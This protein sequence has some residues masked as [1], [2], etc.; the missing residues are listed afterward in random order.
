MR[1]VVF[2]AVLFI[3]LLSG[4]ARA[5]VAHL[6]EGREGW[7]AIDRAYVSAVQGAYECSSEQWQNGWFGNIRVNYFPGAVGLCYQW[8][9]LVFR[10]VAPETC[11]SL[12]VLRGIQVNR[13]NANEHH[14]VV[15]YGVELAPRTVSDL[16][17]DQAWVLDPWLRGAADVYV[18][19]N[20]LRA[21]PGKGADAEFEA[22]PHPDGRNVR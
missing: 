15:V 21:R 8:Q 14:A 16:P 10:A 5:R 20:W 7:E 19:G 6:P 11:A 17:P 18:L 2:A 22:L 9:D 13:G 1:V 12:W 4:C 3:L